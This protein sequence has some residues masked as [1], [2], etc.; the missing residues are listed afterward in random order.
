MYLSN[1]E[2]R[3]LIDRMNFETPDKRFDFSPEEQISLCSIDIRLSNVFWYQKRLRFG[4]TI[5]LKHGKLYEISPTRLWKKKVYNFKDKINIKPGEM[6]IGQTFEK[7]TIPDEFA[8]KIITRSSFS[9]LGI[10][11]SCT[12][13][14]INPG[15]RGRIPLEIINNSKNT[16]TIYALT[17]ICQIMLIPLSSIPD[18]CYGDEQFSS[19]Y[20]D[21]DGSPS[22][23]WRDNL[24]KKI[25]NNL[26][27][28]DYSAQIIN[29]LS[30][31]LTNMEDNC[32]DRFHKYITNIPGKRITTSTEIMQNFVKREKLIHN[33]KKY[34]KIITPS[35]GSIFFGFAIT[36]FN[37]P[38]VEYTKF[39]ILLAFAIIF[40]IWT[41]FL[42][43]DNKTYLTEVEF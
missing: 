30:S 13:D 31:H 40:F 23:W 26:T 14:F 22:L 33:I 11:T 9:R 34:L 27:A 3:D 32:L 15:Y 6:I 17:P 38:K 25:E 4:Q 29:D 42:I 39:G 35:L 28:M 21:E 20:Q 24:M 5:D 37:E 8:G 36:L 12:N 18:G 16:I 2:L 19:K 43:N 7:F 10:E 41:Y 1:N